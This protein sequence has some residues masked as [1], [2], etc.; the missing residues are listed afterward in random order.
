MCR[1]HTGRSNLSLVMQKT[2]QVHAVCFDL[3]GVVLLD[4]FSDIVVQRAARLL[5]AD[6]GLLRDA[7]RREQGPMQC[8]KEPATEFW[9]RVCRSLGM[10]APAESSL[11]DLLMRGYRRHTKPNRELLQVV[12]Q[13][14]SKYRVSLISNTIP[15]HTDV[16]RSRGLFKPF[17]AVIL[18]HEVG[19]RKP[20]RRIFELASAALQRPL[21]DMAFIDDEPEFITAAAR[22]GMHAIRFESN[23]QVCSELRKLLSY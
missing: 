21:T 20:Q 12:A 17:D 5:H 23:A 16:N 14:R 6:A 3:G 15:E 19:V 2:R 4:E 10:E 7:M 18:S 1:R 11:R 8:G 13:L 22:L 9:R